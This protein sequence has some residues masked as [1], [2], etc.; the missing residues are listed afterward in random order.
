MSEQAEAARQTELERLTARRDAARWV[1]G[2]GVLMLFAGGILYQIA[3]GGLAM[4]AYGAAASVYWSRRILRLKGDPWE[5][6]PDLDGPHS[7]EHPENR[8]PPQQDE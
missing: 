2:V 4:M 5:Y 3:L 1:A 8:R 7:L 6:D